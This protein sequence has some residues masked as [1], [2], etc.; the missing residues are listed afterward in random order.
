METAH[1]RFDEWALQAGASDLIADTHTDRLI[2]ARAV[3]AGAGDTRLPDAA[4]LFIEKA[5]AR[6]LSLLEAARQVLADR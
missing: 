2:I 5:R 6:G 1:S 3:R 4:A